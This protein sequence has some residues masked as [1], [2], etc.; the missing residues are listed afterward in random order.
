MT[1]EKNS[2]IK[3]HERASVRGLLLEGIQEKW[4]LWVSGT[5]LKMHEQW[6]RCLKAFWSR[7]ANIRCALCLLG[8]AIDPAAWGL[9]LLFRNVGL[10]QEGGEDG[11][12]GYSSPPA[13]P[14]WLLEGGKILRSCCTATVKARA[15]LEQSEAD[16][17]DMLFAFVR[18]LNSSAFVW[19]QTHYTLMDLSAS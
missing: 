18:A 17:R 8:R 1:K 4:R 13:T 7:L 15:S 9:S 19:R 11:E 10:P 14:G 16:P 12:G 5:V 2:L 6:L 3:V